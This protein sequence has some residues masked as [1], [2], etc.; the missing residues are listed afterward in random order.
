MEKEKKVYLLKTRK[1]S[2]PKKKSTIG[3]NSNNGTVVSDSLL[4]NTKNIMVGV[5]RGSPITTTTA[6]EK[7]LRL[8][9][10]L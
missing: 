7:I 6:R 2:L 3:A 8:E 10:A 5:R 4:V 1:I 9:E